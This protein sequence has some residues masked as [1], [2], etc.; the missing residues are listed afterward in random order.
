MIKKWKEGNK[1]A[2]KHFDVAIEKPPSFFQ[3]K[4]RTVP[5]GMLDLP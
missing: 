4:A 5:K 3:S 2:T 1:R